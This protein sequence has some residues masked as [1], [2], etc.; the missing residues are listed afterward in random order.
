MLKKLLNNPERIT[1]ARLCEACARHT[2]EVYTKVR[3]ADVLPIESSGISD[4]LY[5]F[6]LQAHYDFV[7]T[8]RDHVPLFAVEFDGPNHDET[9]QVDRDLKKNEI[10]RRFRLELLRMRAEDLYRTEQRLDR[11]TDM[12][13]K[14]FAEHPETT[15][16]QTKSQHKAVCPVCGDKMI[17]RRG[18][19]GHFLGCIRYPACVGTCDL[20]VPLLRK[21]GKVLI[22][23]SVA[24]VVALVAVLLAFQFGILG[25]G[26]GRPANEKLTLKERQA[27]ASQID[28]SEY[29][30]CP[31]CGKRM[32]LRE[33]SKTGEPFFGCSDFP[34]CRA[35][36]DIEY[37]K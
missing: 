1:Y 35:T 4:E 5:K 29:P 30:D 23:G 27:F 14:W 13:E 11:L 25:G 34:K 10:S 2:A 3:I 17:L 18:K 8:G 20:P 33:N 9:A 28:K 7:I 31:K 21:W 15:D 24:V 22:A 19:Y 6:A 16:R 37:P 12:I 26:D 32:T 36:R